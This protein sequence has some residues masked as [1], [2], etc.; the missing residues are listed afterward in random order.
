[1]CEPVYMVMYVRKAKGLKDK[2]LS[3]GGKMRNYL[4]Q[5]VVFCISKLSIL[6]IYMS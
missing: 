6:L 5:F 2:R 4:F 1:M 3:P